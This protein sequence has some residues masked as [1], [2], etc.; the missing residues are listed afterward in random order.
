MNSHKTLMRL[1]SLLLVACVAGCDAQTSTAPDAIGDDIHFQLTGAPGEGAAALPRQ[2]LVSWW[3]ADRH[4][5]DIRGKNHLTVLG[6]VPFVSG[7]RGRAFSFAGTGDPPPHVNKVDG[8]QGIDGLQTLTLQAWVKL[9]ATA[10]ANQIQRF[11]TL[12]GEKAVIRQD[13]ENSPRQLHFYMNFG[14]LDILN[15]RHV[16]VNN[17][18]QTECFHHVV[19]T[20]DGSVLRAYLDGV[21]RGTRVFDGTVADGVGIEFSFGATPEALHGAVDDVMV[22]DRALEPS[23]IQHIYNAGPDR[24]KCSPPGG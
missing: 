15:L 12:L 13:G 11:V 5:L 8:A 20:Y 17:I 2:A 23:E 6:D 14:T 7:I 9:D 4:F 1:G 3:P 16:R 10:P 22:F 19:G 21:E 24:D 18:L